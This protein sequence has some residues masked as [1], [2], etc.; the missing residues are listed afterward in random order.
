M[1]DMKR[2]FL[3]Q[4]AVAAM[5]EMLVHVPDEKLKEY[6]PDRVYTLPSLSLSPG[7]LHTA[8][9]DL[10]K[11]RGMS[12]GKMDER[13]ERMPTMV[14]RCHAPKRKPLSNVS[15]P[16]SNLNCTRTPQSWPRRARYLSVRWTRGPIG[17]R[18]GWCAKTKNNI[19]ND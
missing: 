11:A 14:V 3:W 18:R 16:V 17:W 4:V 12:F 1:I 10:A 15:T 13:P 5:E 2:R 19:P 7:E 9:A 8:A 6:G